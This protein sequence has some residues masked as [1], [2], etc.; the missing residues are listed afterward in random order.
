MTWIFQMSGQTQRP[1][2]KTDW[3]SVTFDLTA[4]GKWTGGFCYRKHFRLHMKKKT[5]QSKVKTIHIV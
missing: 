4:G 3:P 1:F 5:R 2:S